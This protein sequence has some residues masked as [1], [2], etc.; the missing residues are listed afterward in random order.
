M[1][2]IQQRTN[3]RDYIKVQDK[4]N[5][6][7]DLFPQ[8][9]PSYSENQENNM[10][11][12][13]NTHVRKFLSRKEDI[14][15]II[16][17]EVKTKIV[18]GGNI[19][20]IEKERKLKFYEQESKEEYKDV[21]PDIIN[22]FNLSKTF[23]NYTTQGNDYG[24]STTLIEVTL[25]KQ[26]NETIDQLSSI[27]AT[28]SGRRYN[29]E[30]NSIL[31]TSRVVKDTAKKN[32]TEGLKLIDK[33]IAA[34]VG[35]D[36]PDILSIY[37]RINSEKLSVSQDMSISSLAVQGAPA[38]IP[39]DSRDKVCGNIVVKSKDIIHLRDFLHPDFEN[40][41]RV[42]AY[43]KQLEDYYLM[44]PTLKGARDFIALCRGVNAIRN[45]QDDLKR[46]PNISLSDC[47]ITSEEELKDLK[48]AGSIQNYL[49]VNNFDL[50]KHIFED[51]FI[52]E[53]IQ[54]ELENRQKDYNGNIRNALMSSRIQETFIDY[55]DFQIA[56]PK[57]KNKEIIVKRQAPAKAY[58]T[59]W[60]S[61]LPQYYDSDVKSEDRIKFITPTSNI[62]FYDRI[63]TA[64]DCGLYIRMISGAVEEKDITGNL[65]ENTV[66]NAKQRAVVKK[67]SI[68]SLSTTAPTPFRVI[69][70]MSYMNFTNDIGAYDLLK[71]A[72][73]DFII[74]AS[75]CKN[76]VYTFL[77]VKLIKDMLETG[78]IL[79]EK[80]IE[81]AGTL[82]TSKDF[83]K[84]LNLVKVKNLS[85]VAKTAR[86]IIAC[87]NTDEL[88]KYCESFGNNMANYAS[89]FN[90]KMQVGRGRQEIKFLEGKFGPISKEFNR[91]KSALQSVNMNDVITDCINN[92]YL[93]DLFLSL[94]GDLF[95]V[96]KNI[97]YDVVS[98]G[99][100]PTNND[101]GDSSVE[102]LN[103]MH[104][105]Y[106]SHRS[107]LMKSLISKFR[108]LKDAYTL[109]PEADAYR[110]YTTLEYKFLKICEILGFDSTRTK[111]Y[112]DKAKEIGTN[113][114][115]ELKLQE[116]CNLISVDNI[117]YLDTY[118]SYVFEHSNTQLR[119]TLGLHPELK[120]TS[121][122]TEEFTSKAED[123]LSLQ[124]SFKQPS[125]AYCNA[126]K[127]SPFYRDKEFDAKGFAVENGKLQIWEKN[128]KHYI[129]R[130]EGYLLCFDGH[131]VKPIEAISSV[132]TKKL[133][134]NGRYVIKE[135]AYDDSYRLLDSDDKTYLVTNTSED[136]LTKTKL[137]KSRIRLAENQMLALQD[138]VSM[139]ED[140]LLMIEDS[141]MK[142][143]EGVSEIIESDANGQ[144]DIVPVQSG[145][146][147]LMK[148]KLEDLKSDIG[149]YQVSIHSD[150]QQLRSIS[151]N[152]QEVYDIT[153]T[154][155][156]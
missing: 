2:Y 151:S 82:S 103:L 52:A 49:F 102:V 8:Y 61:M 85:L 69:E 150:N 46:M 63:Y 11:G 42:Y 7:L 138:K 21:I 147:G 51:K 117:Q 60:L 78:Y 58:S 26:L 141:S 4:V 109:Q 130:K 80:M 152:L 56:D 54:I 37:N 122:N 5:A 40:S 137:I 76:S 110:T 64:E 100:Y 50:D 143:A 112:T 92:S 93:Y 107:T 118:Y 95:W 53:E 75:I 43:G 148:A 123:I 1:Y 9:L 3:E 145:A 83:Q 44:V 70:S 36:A 125:L 33:A 114:E 94:Y 6:V 32:E 91:I 71:K 89:K 16:N 12:L 126:M 81:Y 72:I 134:N 79:D 127:R 59:M 74:P 133:D 101:N 29:F 48:K 14:Q 77:G 105:M 66:L 97:G 116:L 86:S 67:T 108:K 22:I 124:S 45:L 144:Y 128:G 62:E 140:R 96:L 153:I 10:I 24:I 99:S 27:L 34:Y 139:I 113:R 149:K 98:L 90:E 31:G 57:V 65:W 55:A 146:L 47:I 19:L 131:E 39:S 23:L 129:L 84:A 25:D 119:Q 88:Y 13:I 15:K 155:V 38:N 18:K 156:L 68:S 28:T 73:E 136:L 154:K 120:Q 111:D 41:K 121:V 115:L 17:G 87:K 132:K 30:K 106:L 104:N 142:T 35:V 135:I 20:D